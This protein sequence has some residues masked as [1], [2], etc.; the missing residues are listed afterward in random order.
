MAASARID[1]LRHR[2]AAQPRRNLAPLADALRRS[3]AVEEAVTMLR[4]QLAEFPDHLTGH[5]VL[6]QALF[7]T[8]ALADARAAFEHARALDPGN[9]VVLRHLGE[10]A[11]LAG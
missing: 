3:G 9:R 4:A 10:I 2:Y 11:S 6:G 8:G 1:E 5:V 7:D